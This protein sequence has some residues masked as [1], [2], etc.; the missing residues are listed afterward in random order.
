MIFQFP[1][2]I[3]QVKFY[4]RFDL[5]KLHQLKLFNK[6]YEIYILYHRKNLKI[7]YNIYIT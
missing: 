1:Q 5:Y 4:R 2:L 7:Y 6:L 3:N